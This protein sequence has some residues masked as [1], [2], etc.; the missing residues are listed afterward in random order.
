ASMG[1]LALYTPI[2]QRRA[3][4]QAC[5][6]AA[7]SLFWTTTPL[8]LASPAFGLTQNGI[9]LFA[10]AGAAG[11]I[12]TPIAGRLADRGRTTPAT[13]FAMLLAITAFLLAHLCAGGSM[14]Q[15]ALLTFAGIL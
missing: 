7:F 15:L 2:L 9:A 4:Y 12:A 14:P 8:L 6:F 13:A 1:R 3:L 11:A 10:L 5:M